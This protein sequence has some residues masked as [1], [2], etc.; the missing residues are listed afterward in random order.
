MSF[1]DDVREHCRT[2]YVQPA[3]D[4]GDRTVTI[5]AGDVHAALGYSNRYP[6]ICSA[7]G[8]DVFE[9]LCSVKRIVVDGPLNAANTL[10][11]F[12]LL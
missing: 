12:R 4:R 6:L 8:A 7:L 9:K 5:L 1:S 10:F 3:R 2:E 11:I